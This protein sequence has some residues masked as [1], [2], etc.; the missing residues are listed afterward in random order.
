LGVS[1]ARS[2]TLRTEFNI[3]FLP[4]LFKRIISWAE[5]RGE[6]RI[7]QRARETAQYYTE[8]IEG[9]ADE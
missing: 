1:Y 2:S 9:L 4:T 7:G 8:S 5:E 6:E 3:S